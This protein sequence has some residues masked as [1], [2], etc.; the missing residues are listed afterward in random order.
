MALAALISLPVLTTGRLVLDALSPA[1]TDAFFRIHSN[2]DAVRYMAMEPLTERAQA[3]ERLANFAQ[4]CAAGEDLPWAIR[5]TRDAQLVGMCIL[6]GAASS[7]RRA[8]VGYVIAPDEWRQGYA[9]EAVA[10]V[11]AWGFGTLGLNRIEALV[12]AENEAS[13]RTSARPGLQRGRLFARA[14]V[15]EGALLGRRHLPRCSHASIRALDSEG[16]EGLRYAR[17]RCDTTRCVAQA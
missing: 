2:P 10:A 9:R 13:P 14:F 5:R 4:R 15:G 1:D 7:R 12:Y 16:A 11:L 6:K 3:V 8:E 17:T